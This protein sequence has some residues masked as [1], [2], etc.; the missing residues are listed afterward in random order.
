LSI[1]FKKKKE[2]KCSS[3]YHIYIYIYTVVDELEYASSWT[4]DPKTIEKL[5]QRPG[6]HD[7]DRLGLN[8]LSTSH[9]SPE[10]K[11]EQFR[12][13]TVNANF[14]VCRRYGHLF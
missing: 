11:S 7:Y 12:I 3:Q 6:Y 1:I 2:F 14:S 9:H 5:L 13:S 10:P 8:S 4:T